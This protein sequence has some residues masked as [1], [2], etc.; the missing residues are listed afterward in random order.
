MRRVGFL[1]FVNLAILVGQLVQA[2]DQATV[3]RSTP[4]REGRAWVQR[5]EA[6]LPVREGGRLV[7]RSDFGSVSVRTGSS[8]RM[9][10]EL[11]LRAYTSNAN[12]ARRYFE[13]Y[14][15]GVRPLENGGAYVSGSLAGTPRRH[16]SMGAE[17]RI[18]VPQRFNLDI[19]TQGGDVTVEN[20]LQGEVRAITAGG[21]IRTLDVSGPLKA[22]TAGGCVTLGNIGQRVEASTAGGSIRVG[23]VKGDTVLQTSGG[24]IVAGKIEGN[25]RAETAGGDVTIGGARGEIKAETAGGQIRIGE[26]GGSVRAQTAGGSIQLNGARGRVVAETAGGSIDLFQV[27]GGIKAQT[28]AGRI[29]AQFAGDKRTFGASELESAL[30][31]VFVYLP[32]DLPLTI[33]AAIE[34]AL[35]HRIISDFPLNIRGDNQE[36]VVT[37]ISGH[38]ALNGG[39]DILRIRAVGGNIEIRKLDAKTLEQLRARQASEFKA[40]EDRR[41]QNEHRRRARESRHQDPAEDPE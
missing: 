3:K 30:G 32:P 35:G 34:N 37:T 22:E 16:T 26:S 33:D 19:E 41:N 14:G 23:N 20:P 24:E 1:H 8:N 6:S 15:L 36:F 31:D 7:V 21:D 11:V 13:R 27:L 29:L 9:E 40:F 5:A 38:G 28:A 17:F 12:E 18:A 10:C 2:A 4:E 25:L 39:G